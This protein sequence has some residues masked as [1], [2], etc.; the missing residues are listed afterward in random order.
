MTLRTE[1][2]K[3][4]IDDLMPLYLAGE[5][6]EDSR[7]LVEDFLRANPAAGVM[8]EVALPSSL[9]PPDLDRRMLER[10]RALHDRR[11]LLLG[12]A[13]AVS[14]AVF[15]FRFKGKDVVFLLYRDAPWLALVL[16]AVALGIWLAF[17]STCRRLDRT[18]LP[19]TPKS[20]P[21]RG[22]W[23]A[24]GAAAFLPYAFVASERTGWELTAN[25]LV[26]GGF[27]GAAVGMALGRVSSRDES[28]EK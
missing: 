25:F 20:V 7:R 11:G 8:A 22:V 9:P 13:L 2:T 1:V 6:S 18:G 27:T 3:Q 19:G 12:M 28:V 21:A 16:L 5:A 24:G 26:V 23:M 4:V 14:Y 10:A 17:L 15:T